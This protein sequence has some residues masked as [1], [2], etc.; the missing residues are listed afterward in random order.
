MYPHPHLTLL[1]SHS[2]P[3]SLLLLSSPLTP[4][5]LPSL[6]SPLLLILISLPYRYPLSLFMVLAHS[7]WLSPT[8]LFPS[9]RTLFLLASHSHLPSLPL[10]TSLTPL[11]SRSSLQLLYTPRLSHMPPLCQ[12]STAS[13]NALSLASQPTYWQRP[14]LILICSFLLLNHITPL[15]S[16]S[17]STSIAST[18]LP[19][20]VGHVGGIYL[21]LLPAVDEAFR[22]RYR[23]LITHLQIVEKGAETH[24]L[25]AIYLVSG[26]NSERKLWCYDRYQPVKH[27]DEFDVAEHLR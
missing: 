25:Y 16:P 5:L 4:L 12:F 13:P 3:S 11:P 27:I 6:S 17:P 15:P 23:I 1:P 21:K 10:S 19:G 8:L 9:P 22:Y 7:S 2:S 26:T 20:I 14:T 18:S 24:Q